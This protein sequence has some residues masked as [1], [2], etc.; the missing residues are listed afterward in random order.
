MKRIFLTSILMLLCTAAAVA[1][2]EVQVSILQTGPKDTKTGQVLTKVAVNKNATFRVK[3]SYNGEPNLNAEEKVTGTSWK[4]HIYTAVDN[5]TDDD[6]TCNKSSG[7]E[8]EFTFTASAKKA[9]QYF[10]QVRMYLILTITKYKSDMQTVVSTRQ[11]TEYMGYDIVELDVWNKLSIY[12][13][14]KYIP[15]KSALN[16]DRYPVTVNIES[17]QVGQITLTASDGVKLFE[18]DTGG[19]ELTSHSWPA[20]IASKTLYMQGVKTSTKENDQKLTASFSTENVDKVISNVTVVEVKIDTIRWFDK[21]LPERV[22]VT[23]TYYPTDIKVGTLQLSGDKDLFIFYNKVRS[24]AQTYNSFWLLPQNGSTVTLYAKASTVGN[25]KLQLEHNTSGAKAEVETGVCGVDVRVDGIEEKS[26][27]RPGAFLGVAKRKSMELIVEPKSINDDV[28]LQLGA[29]LKLFDAKT[30]GNEITARTWKANQIPSDIY[31]E[32][33]SVS[34][35]MRDQDILLSWNTFSDNAKV[36]IIDGVLNAVSLDDSSP[37]GYSVVT[38]KTGEGAYV[39]WNIDNDDNSRIVRGE[40]AKHPGGDYKQNHVAGENDLLPL[41]MS[42]S[43]YSILNTGI[44]TLTTG[45]NSKIWSSRTKGPSQFNN[46]NLVLTNSKSW[47]FANTTQKNNFKNLAA[48][49]FVEGINQGKSEFKYEFIPPV[50]STIELDKVKY[51]FIAANCGRQPRIAER[52]DLTSTTNFPRLKSCE[53]GIIGPTDSR[54]NCIAYSVGLT[55]R[56]INKAGSETFDPKRPELGGKVS[57]DISYG[58]GNG[59]CEDFEIHEFFRREISGVTLTAKDDPDAKIIYYSGFHAAKRRN[60]SCGK[61]HW[62][63]FESKC[64]ANFILEHRVNQI[65]GT[66]YGTPMYYYK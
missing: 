29:N 12:T 64:G 58:N 25:G 53:W 16:T 63:M 1:E 44:V 40:P 59:T 49:L 28:T 42:L 21:R 5:V 19:N 26:E 30:G 3:A 66:M 61:P 39:H 24:V 46:S 47:N 6:I 15:L 32:G 56:W 60:C 10:I 33:T 37:T 52:N 41:S 38:D 13:G 20:S 17:T 43:P 14:K 2:V 35:S 54:Y 22:P 51:N 18:N 9:K 55:D 45:N 31:L 65:S 48:S 4:Y 50:G 27:V 8:K 11:S 23:M 34:S 7:T 57:I 62:Y 36:T